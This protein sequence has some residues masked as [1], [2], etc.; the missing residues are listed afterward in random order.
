MSPCSEAR[1]ATEGQCRFMNPKDIDIGPKVH[2]LIASMPEHLKDPKN[3]NKIRKVLIEALGGTCS[4]AEMVE[5][6]K[7]PECQQRFKNRR[8]VLKSL[9]FKNPAQYMAWQR[10]HTEIRQMMPLVDWDKPV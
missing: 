10:I 8:G 9:G 4:H 3:Y 1:Q 5:W 7:C 2:P 6:A